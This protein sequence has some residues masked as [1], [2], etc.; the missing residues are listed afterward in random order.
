MELN[1]II[2]REFINLIYNNKTKLELKK[3]KMSREGE[4][5]FSYK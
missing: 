1:V 5:E 2:D 3:M 4:G